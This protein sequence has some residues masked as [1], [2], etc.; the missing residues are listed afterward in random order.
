MKTAFISTSRCFKFPYFTYWVRAI[1]LVC[2]PISFNSFAQNKIW[3][4]T[5]GGPLTD[6]L[7][8]MVATPDGGF[9]LGGSSL[10]NKGADKTEDCRDGNKAYISEP[11]G[12]YWIIKLDANGQKVWDKTYGGDNT[13]NLKT[14]IATSDGGYLLGGFSLSGISG[15]KSEKNRATFDQNKQITPDYWVVKIDANGEK[16]WDKTF[17]GKNSDILTSQVTTADGGFLLG[18]YSDSGKEGDKTQAN[19][20]NQ[21]YCGSDYW[22]VKL[23]ADGSK[24]WDKTFGGDYNESLATVLVTNDGGYLLGGSS[25]SGKSGDK[26]VAPTGN[27]LLKLDVTGKKIWDKVYGTGGLRAMATTTQGGYLLGNADY[28]IT[29]LNAAGSK[30]WEKNYRSSTQDILGTVLVS[31]DGSYLL[32]GISLR[33]KGGHKSEE[34][35]GYWVVKVNKNGDKIWERTFGSDDFSF[36]WPATFDLDVIITPD[37]NFLLGGTAASGIRGDKSEASRGSND[38][39]VVKVGNTDKQVQNITFPTPLLTRTLGDAPVILKAQASSGLPVTFSVISGPATLTQNLLTFTG[40]GRIIIQASQTGNAI[41]APASAINQVIIVDP[42]GPVTKLWD[43][44]I[45]GKRNDQ[46]I[47]MVAAPDGGYLLAGNSNSDK[48]GDKSSSKNG[49]WLVKIDPD[50]K[51]LWDITIAAFGDLGDRFTSLIS[52]T[53]G[54]Y[55]LG[56][57]SSFDFSDLYRVVKISSSGTKQW[58]KAIGGFNEAGNSLDALLATPDGGYLLGGSSNADIGGDKSEPSRGEQDY[59]LVKLDANGNKLWDKTLGGTQ[60]EELTSLVATPDGGYLAGGYS[61]SGKNGDK[62]E[63]NKGIPDVYG[64]LS[65]DYWIVKIDATGKKLWDK[66]WGGDKND[67]LKSMVATPDGGYLVGGSSFSDKSGDKSEINQG[68]PD[69]NGSLTSDYWLVKIDAQGTKIWDETIGGSNY[70]HLAT[71]AATPDGDYLLGGTSTSG[72][73]KDKSGEVRGIDQVYGD[74]WIVKIDKDGKKVW[75]KILGGEKGDEL[76]TMVASPNGTGYILGGSSA[77]DANGDKTE[78]NWGVY[79]FWLVKLKEDQPLA[80]SW[81]RRYGGSGSDNLT[82]TIKTQD[83]GY[84]SGG[85]TNSGVSGDKSLNSQGQNDYWIVKSDKNGKKLWD[86]RYGGSGDDYLHRV[87]QTADGGY[88]LA[89]SSFSNKSGDKSQAS[90]GNRDYWLVKTDQLGNKEWDKTYGGSGKEELV[91]V[92]QLR[93]GEYVL[94]GHSNSPVSGDKSQASQG[95]SDYWILKISSTGTIIWDKRY[96][97]SLAETLGSFVQTPDGGYLLGG[98]SLSGKTGDKTQSS[99]GASDYWV[100]KTDQQGKIVWEKTYGGSKADQ[101]YSVAMNSAKNYFISGTSSSGKSGD[102]TQASQGGQDYWLVTL[103]ENGNKL[104]DR[105]FGGSKDDELRASTITSKGHYILAGHSSSDASG[106]KTQDSQGDSDY[107]VVAVDEQGNKVQD[108]RYGGSEA[109]VLR[110]VTPTKD[111]GLL[112]AGRSASGVSGD[113]TQPSQG[114]TDY[115]LVKVAPTTNSLLAT[116]QVTLAEEP[117]SKTEGFQFQAYPNPFREKVTISFML[118]Q[119]QFAQVKVSDSQGREITTLFKGRAQ[120]NQTYQVEWQGHN[121]VAGMYLVHLNTSARNVTAKILLSP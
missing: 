81:N 89:G 116:R 113:R 100:V 46:L 117:V 90:K 40:I 115:W 45:G 101:V 96:G 65:V 105:T 44:R 71:I 1:W 83:G 30:E 95:S 85:Y 39:W 10:S 72:I 107:W 20:C 57:T 8:A 78:P 67:F 14:V 63:N 17:G 6:K 35:K 84:L 94:G 82:S 25:E 98:S 4:Q 109:E 49:Y 21:D 73:E 64:Y 24:E 76:T 120:A 103:D 51:K 53:D 50:G 61:G 70:D 86:K 91:K 93:T 48:G 47:T 9:L 111:G 112:L 32:G 18:G 80:A 66:T 41:F 104:W 31:P 29:K 42:P 75:D 87:I 56:S 106:D 16:I 102:K 43:K 11:V 3:D 114:S 33:G 97:G 69:A 22:I 60:S 59:W 37:K 79:D 88:L 62:S 28:R 19:K 36:N 110:T 119:T 7:S 23:K 74:Y 118:S 15:D 108:L 34:K 13:D 12:D 2:L 54:G 58:E 68:L 52:T 77:S 121:K 99:Q 38:Y 26:S 55:L 27:W 5:Y 92:I